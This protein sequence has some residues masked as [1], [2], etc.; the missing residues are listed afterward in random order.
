MDHVFI[1]ILPSDENYDVN[2]LN[3]AKNGNH[4]WIISLR[5]NDSVT[6][7]KM[8]TRVQANALPI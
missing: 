1:G 2:T 4:N 6:Q 5:S 8:D 3:N 7:F